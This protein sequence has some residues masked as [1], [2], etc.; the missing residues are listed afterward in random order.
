MSMETP[1]ALRPFL[2]LPTALR[3]AGFAVSP[4]QS[5]DFIEGVGLLGPRDMTDIWRAGRALFAIPQERLAEYDAIFRAIFLGHSIQAPVDGDDDEAV[6]A[7][8][9]TGDTQTLGAPDEDS[10]LAPKR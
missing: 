10:G 3:G 4:D 7:Y 6:D 1:R 2:Q 9:P 5:I 8:E